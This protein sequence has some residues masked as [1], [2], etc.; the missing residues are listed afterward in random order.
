MIP[1]AGPG[2]PVAVAL[3]NA[4]AAAVPPRKDASI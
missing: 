2:S 3:K 1:V 4:V